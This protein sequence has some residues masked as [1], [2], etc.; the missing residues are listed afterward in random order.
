MRTSPA[1]RPS[2]RRSLPIATSP[3]ASTAA[4]PPNGSGVDE[5]RRRSGLAT[6]FGATGA[7]PVAAVAAVAAAPPASA[8][9]A[10]VSASASSLKRTNGRGARAVYTSEPR[11]L[12][13][14]TRIT[15][16]EASSPS[17][18]SRTFVV[19]SVLRPATSPFTL[20]GQGHCLV[21]SA[22]SGP[23]CPS[24]TSGT[25]AID[26]RNSATTGLSGSRARRYRRSMRICVTSPVRPSRQRTSPFSTANSPRP[27][28]PVASA[29]GSAGLP[30]VAGESPNVQ[31]PRPWLSVSSRIVGS[32]SVKRIS[33]T[34]RDNSGNNATCASTRFAR[35]ISLSLPQ[36]AF[37]SVT[38]V[39]CSVG[40]SDRSR[41]ACV[42]SFTSRPV[43]RSSC[44]SIG[45]S[46]VR[47]SI[48]ATTIATAP[49][50]STSRTTTPATILIRRRIQGF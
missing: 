38:S 23:K 41:R 34:R 13:L 10:G 32:T 20:T 27:N 43:A 6:A 30:G 39:S 17:G 45:A 4:K 26:P 37:P 44:A 21:R 19:T 24:S 11:I 7:R 14:P 35:I 1:E 25:S 33:S 50:S 31:F 40:V 18:V 47:V 42:P 3:C 49:S 36:G 16:S 46:S 22:A 5:K 15:R 2:P 12:E 28:A 9:S 8:K 48:V 29:N